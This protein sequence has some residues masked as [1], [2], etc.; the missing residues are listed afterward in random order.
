MILC[1]QS[2]D[3]GLVI[4]ESKNTQCLLYLQSACPLQPS[5]EG[6]EKMLRSWYVFFWPQQT[7]HPFLTWLVLQKASNLITS[8]SHPRASSLQYQPWFAYIT[9]CS[10][11][12]R[13]LQ[14]HMSANGK[15][16]SIMSF[17]GNMQRSMFWEAA[18]KVSARVSSLQCNP[19]SMHKN[20]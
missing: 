9:V 18:M 15:G 14:S 19:Q 8:N 6:A 17:F 1:L 11:K 16:G 13:A 10:F 7:L 2:I 3:K 12:Q 20:L 5:C 4:F